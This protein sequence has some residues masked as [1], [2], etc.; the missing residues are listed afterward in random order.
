VCVVLVRGLGQKIVPCQVDGLRLG[1]A[2][3][4][5]LMCEPVDGSSQFRLQSMGE[6]TSPAD[7]KYA[8]VQANLMLENSI[9]APQGVQP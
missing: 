8:T 4:R 3:L 9:C 7:T 2:V 5:L 6:L 1:F